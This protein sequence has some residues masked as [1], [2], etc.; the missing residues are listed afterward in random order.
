[1]LLEPMQAR[2]REWIDRAFA[3]REIILRVEGKLRC[4]TLS[5]RLQ[6]RATAVA[7]GVCAWA[8]LGTAVFVVDQVR[9]ARLA[10]QLDESRL[11]VAE[12][13]EAITRAQSTTDR[14]RAE[15]AVL[16]A[17]IA[18]DGR[19][20]AALVRSLDP[21]GMIGSHN[22]RADV[23]E[24]MTL[25]D[26]LRR[27]ATAHREL[28]AHATLRERARGVANELGRVVGLHFAFTH[29][30][31]RLRA[32]LAALEAER[33]TLTATLSNV[34]GVL[35]STRE[36]MERSVE[37][38]A[39]LEGTVANLQAR[40]LIAEH[41]NE[42]MLA[43]SRRIEAELEAEQS[44]RQA[45]KAGPARIVDYPLHKLWAGNGPEDA[46]VLAVMRHESA[47]RVDAVS[48]AGALG[49]MQIMPD[50]AAYVAGRLKIGYERSRLI[51]DP[52]F[53]I[54]IGR[55]YLSHLLEL[56][57]GS[58]VLAIAAYNAGPNRVLE[59]I[60]RFGD[61]RRNGVDTRA[62]IDSIPFAETRLYV[63]RVLRSLDFYRERFAQSLADQCTAP[64]S[65]RAPLVYISQ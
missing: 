56:F 21:L 32:Q 54:T 38:A 46:L 49:I 31:A 25:A 5:R 12:A 16:R 15:N 61:P 27:S 44:L 26:A 59:W 55:A 28:I 11:A 62:W 6:I 4:F 52:D 45:A 35:R 65:A 60:E 63:R 40:L 20:F 30:I 3:E 34:S 64:Q 1:M 48:P 33:Q 43:E 51:G 9:V 47:F 24:L 14:L 41:L 10:D 17:E 7:L 8:L 53:N 57:D 19:Q 58:Y 37:R 13:Q 50:T 23:Y 36:E 39:H 29:E 22:S 2:L 18:E 42:E